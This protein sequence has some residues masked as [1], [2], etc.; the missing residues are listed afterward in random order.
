LVHNEPKYFIAN[1]GQ[2]NMQK[3]PPII[4]KLKG[5]KL[6]SQTRNIAENVLTLWTKR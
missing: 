1:Q 5:K 2:R 3:M 6:H 4:S